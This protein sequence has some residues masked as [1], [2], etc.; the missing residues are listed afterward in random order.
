MRSE[1]FKHEILE[2]LNHCWKIGAT[3]Y[4]RKSS[5]SELDQLEKG[6]LHLRNAVVD[7]GGVLNDKGEKVGGG[8]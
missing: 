8:K 1:E 5:R 4:L 7:G 3:G 2:L 6:L